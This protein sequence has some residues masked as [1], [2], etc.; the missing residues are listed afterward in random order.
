MLKSFQ[1][2]DITDKHIVQQ[3]YYLYVY[4]TIRLI[5]ISIGLTYFIGGSWFYIS[6]QMSEAYDA[7]GK[8]QSQMLRG[9]TW[10]KSNDIESLDLAS[11]VVYSQY[12][13]LTVLSTV[14]YGDYYPVGL[15]EMIL[16]ILV[17][18]GGVYF[19][20]YVMG[21]LQHIGVDYDSKLGLIN[22][23]EGLE[24]WLIEL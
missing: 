11:Q 19:F 15:I 10:Y 22:D 5:L 6:Q 18:I 12:F 20:S 14:G 9:G 24:R 16:G 8:D 13:A 21:Q 17:E 2:D 23:K 1:G 3:Y 4:R 7:E